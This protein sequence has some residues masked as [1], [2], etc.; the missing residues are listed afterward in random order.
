VDV[1]SARQT[2]LYDPLSVLVYTTRGSD[3]RTT[4][5]N[6]KVLMKDRQVL[7]LDRSAVLAEARGWAE[8]VRAAV[9]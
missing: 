8:K 5:V 4:I 1:S 9:K 7:T 3:V 2:P 6:G